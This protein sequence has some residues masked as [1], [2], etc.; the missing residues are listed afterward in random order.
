MSLT[1]STS[2]LNNPIIKKT[3]INIINNNII[4]NCHF[5]STD[6]K[7][8]IE[9]LNLNSEDISKNGINDNNNTSTE[10]KDS[11]KTEPLNKN[12]YQNGNANH[13]P[14]T[15][16]QNKKFTS[17]SNNTK[18]YLLAALGLLN[19]IPMYYILKK[20]DSLNDY[21]TSDISRVREIQKNY[22][23]NMRQQ[24]ASY[25]YSV[26]NDL[27][28][29]IQEMDPNI[30]L[31]RS[32]TNQRSK[33]STGGGTDCN[34]DN[35]KVFEKGAVQVNVESGSLSPFQ[36][37][38]LL[39]TKPALQIISKSLNNKFTY[40]KASLS[41]TLYPQNPHVPTLFLDL[42]YNEIKNT[43]TGKI[44]WWF[45]GGTDL[46]DSQL[47]MGLQDKLVVKKDD[48]LIDFFQKF[49]NVLDDFDPGYFHRFVKEGKNMTY[50]THRDELRGV[51][52]LYFNDLNN[53]KPQVL[54]STIIQC[55]AQKTFE[56][57]RPIVE[58][59][60]KLSFNAADKEKQSEKNSRLVEFELVSKL[61]SKVDDS[62]LKNIDK[63]LPKLPLNVSWKKAKTEAEN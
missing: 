48:L 63:T 62:S 8:K 38:E 3:S 29:F 43:S 37:I 57:Y 32:N 53:N 55:F 1:L 24:M 10:K 4:K 39:T 52:G 44:Y 21:D 31:N 35:G 18:Y 58:K 36:V 42:A 25:L 47:Y 19:L 11:L 30:S 50:M 12:N 59:R 16:K 6:N 61:T 28:R 26:Q 54:L 14:I 15:K 56:H 46:S 45:S 49:K 23:S 13:V 2:I 34:F 41:S 17:E 9:I 60:G 20:R 5:Y 51:G 22:D 40:Y 7:P 33:N 27:V